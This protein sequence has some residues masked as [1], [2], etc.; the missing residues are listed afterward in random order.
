MAQ[1][2]PS[3]SPTKAPAPA[4]KQPK[5]S[6]PAVAPAGPCLLELDV[7]ALLRSPEVTDLT[8]TDPVWD[9]KATPG[10]KLLQLPFKINYPADKKEPIEISTSSVRIRGSTSLFW[11]VID[12]AA[13]R[14]KGAEAE[15]MVRDTL[16]KNIPTLA[17]KITLDADGKIKWKLERSLTGATVKNAS[18]S[19]ENDVYILK[20]DQKQLNSRNPGAPPSSRRSPGEDERAWLDRVNRDNTEHKTKLANFNELSRRIR[21]LTDE[22][23]W[24]MPTRI[25][26]VVDLNPGIPDLEIT[27]DPTFENVAAPWRIFVN[28]LT[29]LRKNNAAFQVVSEGDKYILPR[30]ANELIA[31]MTG[32]M[33]MPHFNNYRMVAAEISQTGLTKYAI[34]G[35]PL[36]KLLE[37]LI[38]TG[39]PYVIKVMVK[40]LASVF[41]PTKASGSLLLIVQPFLNPMD[42]VGILRDKFKNKGDLRA[43]RDTLLDVNGLM[44]DSTAAS[45]EDLLGQLVETSDSPELVNVSAGTLQ[46]DGLAPDR[47]TKAIVYI[48]ENAPTSLLCSRLLDQKLLGSAVPATQR[49][50]LDL[51][52]AADSA[53]KHLGDAFNDYILDIAFGAPRDSVKSK[54]R[55]KMTDRILIDSA[56][57]SLFRLLTNADPKVQELAWQSLVHFV[58]ADIPDANPDL[59]RVTVDAALSRNPVPPQI[60]EFLSHQGNPTRIVDSFFRIILFAKDSQI[61]VAACKALKTSKGAWPIDKGMNR[62]SSGDRH[63]LA[64]RIYEFLTGEKAPLVVGLLRQRSDNLPIAAWFGNELANDRLPKAEAWVTQLND[65]D[66]LLELVVAS[67]KD[68]AVGACSALLLSSGGDDKLSGGLLTRFQIIEEPSPEKIKEEWKTARQEIYA[69]RVQKLAGPIRIRVEVLEK[70][71]PTG[72]AIDAPGSKQPNGNPNLYDLGATD[73][74]ANNEGIKLANNA[75]T[76]SIATTQLGIRIEKPSEVKVINADLLAKVPLEKITSPSLL[77]PRA[78][79]SWRGLALLADGKT[80]EFSFIP[81]AP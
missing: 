37:S 67:D 4:V 60:V 62:I 25:W 77:S 36:Y 45:P 49:R 32:M 79:G 80:V 40:E 75:L 42:R 35:D 64:V 39:D 17:R 47:L 34:P 19:N 54:N 10:R 52:A 9:A 26:L 43:F 1:D 30:E 15:V 38:R 33:A 22:F 63:G 51:L 2:A 70:G 20:I 48:I 16:P 11:H 14:G 12:E 5:A 8:I 72:A 3:T 31:A 29:L 53:D 74:I 18:T 21:G 7:E 23:E 69:A 57:H 78:D 61:A 41:P 6:D 50:T 46:F 71:V 56:S 55:I 73:F 68:L 27:I 24:T 44:N 59:Y 65:E 28:N 66:R 13:P 81:A 76:M 58:V